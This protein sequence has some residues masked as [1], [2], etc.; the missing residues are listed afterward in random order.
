[1]YNF[2]D[3]IAQSYLKYT[4]V[5]ENNIAL[6]YFQERH[7]IKYD[8]KF[9]FTDNLFYEELIK[10]LDKY[11]KTTYDRHHRYINFDH[12]DMD[13]EADMFNKWED[14]KLKKHQELLDEGGIDF[15]VKGV[16]WEE[17]DNA[18]LLEEAFDNG[19]IL[20]DPVRTITP[21]K[22]ILPE[23]LVL[24]KSKLE[25][26]KKE[27][28]RAREAEGIADLDESIASKNK[29]IDNLSIK[30][31]ETVIDAF[32]FTK[33]KNLDNNK[34]I[35]SEENYNYLV[36]W[37]TLYYVN[38]LDSDKDSKL[39]II[40]SPLKMPNIGITYIRFAFK[41]LN[42]EL[43]PKRPRPKSFYKFVASCFIDKGGY[44]E[45][46]IRG[47]RQPDYYEKLIAP[48]KPYKDQ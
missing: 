46:L 23:D 8:N 22:T 1:M 9:I 7:Q 38:E 3:L 4:N 15:E 45:D 27:A 42:D 29:S 30:I 19:L 39:P 6:F 43:N 44:T 5:K 33:K 31:E 12:F 10:V 34:I 14:E 41:E 28:E 13:F 48:R 40:D 36:K 11:I 17:V 2:T 47:T 18:K 16:N 24:R 21:S 26:L 37:T 25:Y 32:R 35:L 20:I